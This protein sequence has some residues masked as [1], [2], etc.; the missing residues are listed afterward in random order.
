MKTHTI[1]S[2]Y[3]QFYVADAVLKPSPPVEWTEEHIKQRFNAL[4]SIV[5]LCPEG[6]ISARVIC[7]PPG[8]SFEACKEPDFV[9]T[10]VILI[11]SGDIGIYEWPLD[12][13]EEFRVSPGVYTIQFMGFNTDKVESE[14]DFYTVEI[15]G[16]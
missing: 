7:V 5:A 11:E 14:Q 3:R 16:G 10:T 4:Q 2:I 9:V 1:N 6:D 15:K 8:E 13:I 12:P